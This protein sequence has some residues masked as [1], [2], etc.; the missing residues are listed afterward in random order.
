MSACLFVTSICLLLSPVTLD[1]C[2]IIFQLLANSAVFVCI[3]LPILLTHLNSL[4]ASPLW[5]KVYTYPRLPVSLLA[6]LPVKPV[7]V[8]DR[9]AYF[10]LGSVAA[11]PPCVNISSS[12]FMCVYLTARS[13]RTHTLIHRNVYAQEERNGQR[14]C[15]RVWRREGGRERRN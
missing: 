14:E 10:L 2:C 15:A 1:V 9:F 6:N 12:S 4:E 11:N 7:F 5:Q 8:P 13:G 3:C